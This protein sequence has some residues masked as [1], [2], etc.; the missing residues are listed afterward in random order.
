M[1]PV[2]IHDGHG[3]GHDA[4][5]THAGELVVVRG[6]YDETSTAVM[7]STATAYNLAL[8]RDEEA[9]IITGFIINANKNVSATDG[10]VIELYEANSVTSTTQTKNLLTLNLLKNASESVTGILIKATHGAYINAETDDATVNITLLGYYLPLDKS[11][12]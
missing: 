6:N 5:I 9:F 8:P 3:Q 1:I 7:S 4:K 10:A 11:E 12:L 2:K